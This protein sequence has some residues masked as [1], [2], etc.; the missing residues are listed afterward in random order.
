MQLLYKTWFYLSSLL[1]EN[2]TAFLEVVVLGAG[3][4]QSFCNW[5]GTNISD[6]LFCVETRLHWCLVDN[7]SFAP[8][9]AF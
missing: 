6:A 7:D 3:E 5:T 4:M 2:I 1:L 9:L 8:C